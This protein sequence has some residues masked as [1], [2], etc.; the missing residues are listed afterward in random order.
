V[1]GLKAAGCWAPEQSQRGRVE[2]ELAGSDPAAAA[3]ATKLR[4]AACNAR[5]QCGAT[6]HAQTK[7]GQHKCGGLKL[8]A[9]HQNKLR[10]AGRITCLRSTRCRSCWPQSRGLHRHDR[11]TDNMYNTVSHRCQLLEVLGH[12][13]ASCTGMQ[14]TRLHN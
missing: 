9:R 4:P 14:G 3:V 6:S 12:K 11:H 8:A 7:T 2:E 13:E 5:K 10:K 1:M